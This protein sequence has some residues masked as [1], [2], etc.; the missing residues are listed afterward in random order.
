MLTL[1]QLSVGA[2]AIALL[3][4]RLT[5]RP[6][7]SPLAQ[8]AFAGALAI[9][10]LGASVLHLGR[11]RLAWRAVFG[12]RTSWLSREAIAFGLYALLAL[13]YGVLVAGPLLPEFPAKV[14]V[15]AGRAVGNAAALAGVLGVFCSVMVYVATRRAQWSGTQ[16]GLKFCCSTL[17]LGAATVLTVCAFTDGLDAF[18]KVSRFLFLLVFAVTLVKLALEASVLYHYRDLHHSIRKRVAIVMLGD[19]RAATN[20]RFTAAIGG[21]LFLPVYFLLSGSQGRATAA[22]TMLMLVLLATGELAERYLFSRGAR[23][24]HARRH[25]MKGPRR[26]GPPHARAPAPAE[27]IRP[28]SHPS[29]LAADQVTSSDLRLLFHR[30]Q[31]RHPLEGGR[32]SGARADEGSPGQ[33]GDG[34]PEGVGGTDTIAGRA[35]HGAARPAGVAGSYR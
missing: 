23:L 28:G 3:V 11:P 18:G 33:P 15:A 7:G 34:L 21:G 22:V 5:G 31:P 19:L 30:L 24:T 10:A 29:R 35:R 27:Q 17:L 8:A 20:L 26:D 2:F 16:T 1:T 4:E 6:A 32:S 14:A 12:W 25:P 13:S 9:V